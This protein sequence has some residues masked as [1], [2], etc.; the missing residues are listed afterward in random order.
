MRA[1]PLRVHHQ[2]RTRARRGE[3]VL[4]VWARASWCKGTL[5]T[6]CPPPL[7]PSPSSL[8]QACTMWVMSVVLC[9]VVLAGVKSGARRTEMERFHARQAYDRALCRLEGCGSTFTEAQV[10]GVA[11]TTFREKHEWM[12]SKNVCGAG[13]APLLPIP[14]TCK[15]LL[16][17]PSTGFNTASKPFSPAEI[18]RRT[19]YFWGLMQCMVRTALTPPSWSTT[20]FDSLPKTYQRVIAKKGKRAPSGLN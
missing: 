18:P 6:L 13:R 15:R 14:R 1:A 4:H 11:C 20:T 12:S 19:L 2:L 17:S 3:R 16:S 9:S 10:L 7:Q 8:S 5:H